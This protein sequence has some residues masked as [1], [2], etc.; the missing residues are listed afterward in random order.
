LLRGILIISLIAAALIGWLVWSQSNTPPAIVSG[1]I[2]ADEIR[3]GSRIG[4]RV[5][6]VDVEEGASIKTSAPIF[7]LD[8]YDLHEQ[9][10]EAEAQLAAAAAEADRLQSGYRTEEIEQARARRDLAKVTLDKLIAGPRPHELAM[11]AEDLRIAQAELELSEA[12][13][14]RID[15]LREDKQAA[16]TE[17]DQATRTRK[18]WE[19]RVARAEQALAVLKEGTRKE[20]IAEGRAKLA[21]AEH[22][23]KLMEQGFRKEE[24]AFAAAKKSAAEADVAAIKTRIGE[25][26]VTSPCDCEV[27]AIELRPG[28]MVAPNAPTVALL[29][30][31]RM[32]IRTYVPEPMLPRV[33]PGRKFAI[34]VDG[35]ENRR[36]IGHVAFVAKE[37]EFT[38]RNV[39]TPEERSKQV[40][41]IKLMI[42]E[43]RE[44]LRVGMSADVLL[45]EEVK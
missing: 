22:A 25:L 37:A 40:F 15:R 41:R 32:W 3:V 29:D 7:Q 24:I 17:Y 26:S 12:E 14:K 19:A 38:P 35:I 28:D 30:L 16:P 44:S 8:E 27:E 33:K 39:Q 45:D 36:F 5:S 20:E 31:S 11:A 34:R 21:E 2:E 18:A 4:G 6:R 23:L 9:L 43:G 42:D 10:K 13:Y 1:Y